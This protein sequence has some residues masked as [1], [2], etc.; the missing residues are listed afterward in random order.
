MNADRNGSAGFFISGT[1]FFALNKL[2]PRR[3]MGE[4]DEVDVYGTFTAA[5]AAKLGVCVLSGSESEDMLDGVET[6][7]TKGDKE[8]AVGN[9]AGEKERVAT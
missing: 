9:L 3:G 4:Y 5:E 2:F 6:V 1:I 7:G 8:F